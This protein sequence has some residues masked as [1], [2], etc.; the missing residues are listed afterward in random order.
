MNRPSAFREPSG[1]L[2]DGS[3]LRL[4]LADEVVTAAF[5]ELSQRGSRRDDPHCREVRSRRRQGAQVPKLVIGETVGLRVGQR[6]ANPSAPA[7]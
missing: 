4:Q 7:V 2:G 5:V 6:R 3:C 1:R